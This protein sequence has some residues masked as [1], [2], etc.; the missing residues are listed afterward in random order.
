MREVINGYRAGVPCVAPAE[1]AVGT[2]HDTGIPMRLMRFMRRCAASRLPAWFMVLIVCGLGFGSH[3]AHAQSASCSPVGTQTVPVPMDAAITV[4][5]DAPI[6]TVLTSWANTALNTY[7]NCQVSGSV[8]TGTAF[9]AASTL[10]KTSLTVVNPSHGTLTVWNTTTPGIGIAVVVNPLVNG[11]SN[12]SWDDLGG[13]NGFFP[14]SPWVGTACNQ[15]GSAVANGGLAQVAL[16]K[17]GP[18]TAGI[19]P[20]GTLFQ[21]SGVWQT[22]SGSN[23]TFS[24]TTA[25]KLFSLSP[26]TI[27]VSA[28]TTPNVTV[29]LGSH[30]QS[31]FTGIGS[32]TKIPKSFNVAV[33]ACP[34]GLTTIQYEFDPINTVLDSTNG[35]LALSSDST[36]T[37]IGIQLKDGS[38]AALKYNA[39]YTL[40][41]YNKA[42][43][44]SYTIPLTAAYY[45]TAASVTPG[46]ANVV[47][48]FLMNYQ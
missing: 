26:T 7:Y 9:S 41:S 45:Q 3:A 42:T 33:N 6:G 14:N 29:D 8:F 24:S 15:N 40:S 47:L 1:A 39:K 30:Q 4:S 31:E 35:V 43:G 20:G 38:G 44:G 28:C 12:K 19:F 17:T 21:A 32:A 37:G 10:T 36:A 13:I 16:V 46:S 11:C 2:K 18:I 23:Y 22:S 25:Q 48:N 5:R 27:S 34:A